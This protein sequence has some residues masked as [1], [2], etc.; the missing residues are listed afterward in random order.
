MIRGIKLAPEGQKC[1]CCWNPLKEEDRRG[2]SS[3]VTVDLYS[4]ALGESQGLELFLCRA[5]AE[6]AVRGCRPL[7]GLLT[8]GGAVEGAIRTLVRL[9]PDLEK[10]QQSIE[11]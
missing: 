11:R 2:G 7:I 5:C 4:Q 3:Y 1:F 6:Y 10:T 9:M 8:L